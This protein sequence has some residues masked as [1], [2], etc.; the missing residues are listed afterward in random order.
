VFATRA[1]RVARQVRAAADKR[2]QATVKPQPS[3]TFLGP[4][5]MSQPLQ[6]SVRN[7]G[8]ALTAGAVVVQ[9][10]EDLF[11]G[12]IAMPEKTPPQ[13]IT[14]RPLIKAWKST[15]A[16][17]TL[18]LA[19]RDIEGR[20]WDFLADGKEIKN[21]RRWIDRQVRDL[22]LAGIV[23]FKELAGGR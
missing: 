1:D 8:G 16:P 12:E 3:I 5:P 21:P 7:F 6:V 9:F 17:R 18:L 23:D 15:G 20:C 10:G 14:L 13:T 11:G 4:T 22:R 19:G 2:W